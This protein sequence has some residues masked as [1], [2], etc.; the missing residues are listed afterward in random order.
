[1]KAPKRVKSV[2]AYADVGSHGGIFQF[3]GGPVYSMYGPLMHIWPNKISSE[4]VPVKIAA[5]RPA[6]PRRS[7]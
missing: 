4:L 1:M 3:D 2:I 5:L 6:R 7:K